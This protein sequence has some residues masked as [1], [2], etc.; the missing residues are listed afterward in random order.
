MPFLHDQRT[1]D[2]RV[3]LLLMRRVVTISLVTTNEQTACGL[4]PGVAYVPT[5]G[6]TCKE[7][8][9]DR[10][11]SKNPYHVLENNTNHIVELLG[12]TTVYSNI[13]ESFK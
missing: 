8:T 13:Q 3:A 2:V 11:M 4:A 6:R 10:H 5:D 1:N 9:E 7:A 12:S